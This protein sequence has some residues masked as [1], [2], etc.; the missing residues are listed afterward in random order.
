MKKVFLAVLIFCLSCSVFVN[1]QTGISI[2][3]TPQI[4]TCFMND[5][6]LYALTFINNDSIDFNGS[7]AAKATVNGFP[8][9]DLITGSTMFIPADTFVTF[10]GLYLPVNVAS[11]FWTGDN[12]VVIWPVAMTLT[13]TLI[14]DTVQ[15]RIKVNFPNSV[16]DISILSKIIIGNNSKNNFSI[17]NL[18]ESAIQSTA[19]YDMSGR[20]VE[21]ISGNKTQF[22]LNHFS[23]GLYIAEVKLE[24]SRTAKFKIA[25]Q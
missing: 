15:K 17:Y 11:S 1:A 21:L 9:A 22:Y 7:L 24:D 2:S 6:L 23:R 5:N 10:S 4:D 18:T 19:I 20:L 25:V 12:V 8:H 14:G 13:D 16:N 3:V